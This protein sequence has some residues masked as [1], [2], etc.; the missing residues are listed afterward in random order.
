[1][2]WLAVCPRV[3][4]IRLFASGSVEDYPRTHFGRWTRWHGYVQTALQFALIVESCLQS[5][6]NLLFVCL[7]MLLR[8]T[9]SFSGSVVPMKIDL[10]RTVICVFALEPK[11]R[12]MFREVG[13]FVYVMSV[14]M[15]MEG[16]LGN[17]LRPAWKQG[18]SEGRDAGM[19]WLGK[20]YSVA[21]DEDGTPCGV[22]TSNFSFQHLCTRKIW[23]M[24]SQQACSKLVKK[25]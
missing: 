24:C 1:M 21:I 2:R 13:G 23:D 25:S 8:S 20:N 5:E 16:A 19:H 6:T 15:S 4:E 17:E 22:E 18:M 7:G 11:T 9:Q 14:L 3:S 12:A 10:L